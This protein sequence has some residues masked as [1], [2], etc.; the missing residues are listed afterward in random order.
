[1]PRLFLKTRS[2]KVEL[3]NVLKCW[4][5]WLVYCDARLLEGMNGKYRQWPENSKY[6]FSLLNSILKVNSF[7]RLC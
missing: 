2:M 5:K 4:K 7:Q 6:D 3:K 1:M